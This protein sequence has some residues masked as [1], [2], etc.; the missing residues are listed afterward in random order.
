MNENFKIYN[1][2]CLKEHENIETSS[3]DLILTDLPYGIMK[4]IDKYNNVFEKGK[5]DWDTVLD[6]DKIFNIASRILKR[7]SKMLLFSQ[8]PFTT[9]LLAKQHD[10]IKHIYQM[11]WEKEHFGNPL[12]AKISP[13]SYIEEICVFKKLHDRYDGNPLR[14]YAEQCKKY[15]NKSTKEVNAILG[16][17]ASQHFLCYDG[18]QFALCTV[19]TYEELIKNFKLNKMVGFKG[20]NELVE[21]QE[22]ANIKTKSIF[23]LWDGKGHKPNLLKYAKDKDKYHP[24]QKP[25]KLLEDLI[26][27]FSNEGDTI[28]DLTMGSGSTGVASMNTG[29]N[30][31]GIEKDT[32]YFE[33]AKKR[34]E[35]AV[36]FFGGGS[37]HS[38]NKKIGGKIS[39]TLS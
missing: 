24:T 37:K 32:H 15:I 3:V 7:N 30:F 9:K 6:S 5:Y 13:V 35:Y 38:L 20:Y 1:G 18:L 14:V 39:A 27:T 34:I 33:I 23:N 36:K 16:N 21:M 8:Q 31:I 10:G 25:V 29:R 26:K 4:G 28:C 19:K 12:C 22:K 17:S 11:Y 2:D